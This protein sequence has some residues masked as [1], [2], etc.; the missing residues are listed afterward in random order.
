[1]SKIYELRPVNGQKSF[2][3]KALVQI[4]K[5]GSEI[6]LSYC[7]PII[8]RAVNG[9][10]TRL[11]AGWSQTT[12]KHIKAFCGLDKAGFMALPHD[13]TPAEKAEAYSGTL[14]R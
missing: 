10:L 6:L 4:E 11:Y 5:D 8:K 13:T 12:G 3:G 1:M 14:Y 9:D 7:T 2:N